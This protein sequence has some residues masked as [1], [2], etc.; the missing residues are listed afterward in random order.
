MVKD[1]MVGDFPVLAFSCSKGSGPFIFV[2]TLPSLGKIG[3]TT[4]EEGRVFNVCKYLC[5]RVAPLSS[6]NEIALLI[7]KKKNFVSK[8]LNFSWFTCSFFL[9]IV[10]Y[11]L[12]YS[13]CVLGSA[14]CFS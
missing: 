8:L 6:F 5:T 3:S 1:E 11:F 12:M 7:K 9:L 13:S 2:L 10:R 4:K 14:L